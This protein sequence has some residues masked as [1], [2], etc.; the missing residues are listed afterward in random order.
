MIWWSSPKAHMCS[1]DYF[2]WFFFWEEHGWVSIT[3]VIAFCLKY[4]VCLLVFVFHFCF[5]IFPQKHRVQQITLVMM[6]CWFAKE[7][8]HSTFLCST[9]CS[10]LGKIWYKIDIFMKISKYILFMKITKCF[11]LQIWDPLK[12]EMKFIGNP[13]NSAYFVQLSTC[14]IVQCSSITSQS[15]CN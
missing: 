1:R 5:L 13:R 11:F 6:F 15:K 4:S 7:R 12:W 10:D 2:F 9:F 8:I 3:F 14:A